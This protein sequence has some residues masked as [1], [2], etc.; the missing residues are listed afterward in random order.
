LFLISIIPSFINPFARSVIR[1][2]I[3]PF[4]HSF[5]RTILVIR[6]TIHS[7]RLFLHRLCKSATTQRRTRHSTDTVSEFHAE[8]PLATASEGLAQGPTW[9]L[10]RD[11]NTLPFRGKASELPM[12]HHTPQ[13]SSMVLLSN[14]C[15]YVNFRITRD[16]FSLYGQ[17]PT[18]RSCW[19]M[20]SLSGSFRTHARTCATSSSNCLELFG[21]SL[22]NRVSSRSRSSKVGVYWTSC[23]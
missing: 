20:V 5:G 18:S 23:L 17:L 21:W 7:F 3:R 16:L 11:S 1:S 14:G 22:I 12:S 13:C 19:A 15:V 2:I 6:S 8:A 10:E 9:W 4:R